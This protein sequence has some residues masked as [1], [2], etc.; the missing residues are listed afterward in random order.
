MAGHSIAQNRFIGRHA[1][2]P[3]GLGQVRLVVNFERDPVVD[4]G[5]AQA[6]VSKRQRERPG[7]QVGVCVK[8]GMALDYK[9]S[10]K[11]NAGTTGG[12]GDENEEYL[13]LLKQRLQK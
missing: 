4:V 9:P 3:R 10:C 8:A 11:P 6:R 13:N 7:W 12:A 1:R 5:L 2:P